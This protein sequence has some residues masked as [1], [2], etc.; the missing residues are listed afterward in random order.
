MGEVIISTSC[1][2]EGIKLCVK[3]FGIGIP[4]DCQERLFTRF[5]RVSE[6]GKANTFPGLGLG[7]YI[8]AEIIKRH[9]GTITFESEAGKGSTF[10]FM[11]P[12]MRNAEMAK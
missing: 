1:D 9:N 10:C 7:L 11:L 5:Y 2:D 3:D 4:K 12:N 8:S 6:A